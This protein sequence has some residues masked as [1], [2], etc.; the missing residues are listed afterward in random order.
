MRSGRFSRFA[1]AAIAAALL[2]VAVAEAC[3]IESP[4]QVMSAPATEAKPVASLIEIVWLEPNA[5]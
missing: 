1:V 5:E 2:T 4:G 3:D